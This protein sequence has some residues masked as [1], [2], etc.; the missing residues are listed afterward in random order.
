[1]VEL[2]LNGHP[3]IQENGRLGDD[4]GA[5]FKAVV[6]KVPIAIRQISPSSIECSLNPMIR[7]G[8]VTIVFDVSRIQ[9]ERAVFVVANIHLVL[10]MSAQ[11]LERH[12]VLIVFL[13][14]VIVWNSNSLAILQKDTSSRLEASLSLRIPRCS[15]RTVASRGI[16]D[17]GKL[18]RSNRVIANHSSGDSVLIWSFTGNKVPILQFDFEWSQKSE[19]RKWL[20]VSTFFVDSLGLDKRFFASFLEMAAHFEMIEVKIGKNERGQRLVS[21]DL[22]P[23]LVGREPKGCWQRGT[24]QKEKQR[25][26]RC[27]LQHDGRNFSN[28]QEL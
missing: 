20:G 11:L 17:D 7:V 24:S 26:A 19:N 14:I 4:V 15:N 9:T 1:M 8:E 18:H 23:L 10:G 12:A 5:S 21:Q 2:E 13:R 28:F 3:K 25:K 27:G 16:V 22:G 6:F